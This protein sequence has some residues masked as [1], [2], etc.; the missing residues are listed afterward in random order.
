MTQRIYN[1]IGKADI[2]VDDMIG[3]NPNVFYETGYAHALNKR[4]VLLTQK[5][6]DIPFDLKDYPHIVYEG[7]IT[8]LKQELERR[9]RWWI[10]HPTENLACID[11]QVNVYMQMTD[12]KDYTR[13]V[14]VDL[15]TYPEFVFYKPQRGLRRDYMFTLAFHNRSNQIRPDF[16]FALITPSD[17]VEAYSANEPYS[18]DSGWDHKAVTV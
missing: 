3:R 13:E 11:A 17:F 15:S 9:L 2:I 5:A 14:T 6:E 4:V 1:Q 12:P 8:N 7:K 16:P 18:L 10:D